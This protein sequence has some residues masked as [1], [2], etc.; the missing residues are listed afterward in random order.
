MAFYNA[1]SFG[2][3]ADLDASSTWRTLLPAVR[4]VGQFPDDVQRWIDAPYDGPAQLRCYAYLAELLPGATLCQVGGTGSHAVKFLL[5][6]AACS[7]VVSPIVGEVAVT[8]ACARRA[9]VA[10]GLR[11]VVATGEALPLPDK[12]V[13]GIFCGGTLHHM[14]T[15]KAGSQFARVLTDGGR[16][17]AAEPWKVPL[18]HVA[19]TRAL[20][21]REDV[22]CRP[23]DKQRLEA[24]AA[25][26]RS[27]EDA[28]DGAVE[29]CPRRHGA[30]TRYPLLALSK[31]GVRPDKGRLLRWMLTDDAVAGGLQT[32]GSSLSLLA[33]TSRATGAGAGTVALSSSSSN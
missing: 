25:G 16:V 7:V 9:G 6:G 22:S 29:L 2:E 20:G 12:S 31:A 18:L 23:I 28:A 4:G 3:A 11:T 8:A 19:G 13:D 30:L 33:A 17:A 21:K 1:V 26:F 10:A 24:F 32:L 5:A 14:D 27:R 15:F